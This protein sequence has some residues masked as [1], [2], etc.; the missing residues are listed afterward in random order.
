MVESYFVDLLPEDNRFERMSRM[1]R[2]L[3]EPLVYDQDNWGESE[4]AAA[5]ARAMEA[6][7]PPAAP[8]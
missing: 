2:W 7:S 1:R 8:K 4:E 5:A 6:M 3:A